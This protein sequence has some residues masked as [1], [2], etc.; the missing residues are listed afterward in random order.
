MPEELLALRDPP[1]KGL[2]PSVKEV[3][4]YFTHPEFMNYI[5]YILITSGLHF[6]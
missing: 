1:I 6:H 4:H 2:E 5:V 3:K